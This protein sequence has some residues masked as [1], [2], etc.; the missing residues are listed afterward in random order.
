M[1]RFA[2]ENFNVLDLE[3]VY[4]R[5]PLSRVMGPFSKVL[6]RISGPLVSRMVAT[7]TPISSRT[8]LS[9]VS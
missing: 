1:I 9:L 8:R 6:M 2:H 7:G 5:Q 3:D 4:K